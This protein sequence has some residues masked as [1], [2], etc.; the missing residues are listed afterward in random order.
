MADDIDCDYIEWLLP[1]NLAMDSLFLI[2]W[3]LMTDYCVFQSLRIP[4]DNF[5]PSPTYEES[6]SSILR[7]W[8]TN[9]KPFQFEDELQDKGKKMINNK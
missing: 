6:P 5:L 2:N 7:E 8:N 3:K 1:Y 4:Q 9:E